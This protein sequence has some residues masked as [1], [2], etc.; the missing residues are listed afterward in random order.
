MEAPENLPQKDKE[1]KG[2]LSWAR[3]AAVVAW[4][5][6]FASVGLA[7]AQAKWYVFHPHYLP[8]CLLFAAIAASTVLALACCLRRTITGPRR[9]HAAALAA[10]IVLPAAFWGSVGSAAKKNWERRWVPNT[11]AMRMAKVM[12]ATLMRAEADL[13]YRHRLETDRLVMYYDDLDHPDEDLAIMDQHVARL[14]GLLGGRIERKA[15]WIRG[16]LLGNGFCSLHG[17]SLGSGKMLGDMNDLS[18]GGGRGDRHELAHAALDWFRLPGSDPPCVL[19]EGWAMAQCGDAALELAEAAAKSRRD[20][21]SVGVRELFGADWYHRD[22]GPVYSIGGAFVDFMIRTR[23]AA[24]F[25]RLYTECQPNTVD[26]KCREIFA[27][28]LDDLEAKFWEDVQQTLRD[29]RADQ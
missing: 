18:R 4:L 3:R 23:G 6:G 28:T 29:P 26:V 7:W 17:L 15:Y 24:S 20:N 16:G 21:P 5:C 11:F 22:T 13:R 19:H 1:K 10:V 14:E 9:V 27:I 12:G 25:R 2:D 8:L